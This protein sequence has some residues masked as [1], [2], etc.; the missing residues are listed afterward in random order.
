MFH[1]FEYVRT[2]SSFFFINYISIA[3][4]FSYMYDLETISS[5]CKELSCLFFLGKG[6]WI[7]IECMYAYS[8]HAAI[9]MVCFCLNKF[10]I[11][12]FH[13]FV[14]GAFSSSD[15]NKYRADSAGLKALTV[16]KIREGFQVVSKTFVTRQGIGILYVLALIPN[17]TTLRSSLKN[18]NKNKNEASEI[19][20]F[21]LFLVSFSSNHRTM[22]R[23]LW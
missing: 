16:E 14:D 1:C 18:K 8:A 5:M 9:Q 17:K 22:R 6:K 2:L 19:F 10:Q 3:Q 20:F 15:D 23:I 21:F 12:S 7:V 4:Q 11:A 13:M